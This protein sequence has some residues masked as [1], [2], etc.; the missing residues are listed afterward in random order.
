MSDIS[1]KSNPK[2][3]ILSDNIGSVIRH[4]P[5][6]FITEIRLHE[7]PPVLMHFRTYVLQDQRHSQPWPQYP[8][9]EHGG[10]Y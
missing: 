8:R 2:S 10:E 4:S 3:A 7:G 5:L 1:Y 6:S 9:Q